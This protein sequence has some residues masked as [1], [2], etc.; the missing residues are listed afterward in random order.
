MI[1]LGVNLANGFLINFPSFAIES[2]PPF[3]CLP[4]DTKF[5]QSF[6]SRVPSKVSTRASSRKKVRDNRL[7]SVEL[8]LRVSNA[9]DTAATGPEVN[10]ITAICGRYA[11]ANM[12]VVTPIDVVKRPASF[13]VRGRHRSRWERKYKTPLIGYK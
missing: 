8:S 3:I 1:A 9:A 4:S 2:D 6:E 7:T 13:E 11:N 5:V 10:A 12:K